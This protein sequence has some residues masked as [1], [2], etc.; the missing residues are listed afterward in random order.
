VVIWTI[1]RIWAHSA[2]TFYA[3]G[4]EGIHL[5]RAGE[6]L[7]LQLDEVLD[8]SLVDA[9]GARGYI[10]Q[11]IMDTTYTLPVRRA[12]REALRFC[13]VDVARSTTAGAP[14]EPSSRPNRDLVLL[15]LRD[16]IPLL[17]S[18]M[19]GRDLVDAIAALLSEHDS[20]MIGGRT[21]S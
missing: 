18:P 19:H 11:W 9:I 5:H 1:L 15:R 7:E 16:R 12:E 17:L 8:A 20:P 14:A 4:P 10:R 3:V 2:Q 13:T 21:G 6:V